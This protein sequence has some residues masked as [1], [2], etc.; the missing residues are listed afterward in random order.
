MQWRSPAEVGEA[1]R[2][3]ARRPAASTETLVICM[4]PPAMRRSSPV[5]TWT[6]QRWDSP[7]ASPTKT[8]RP[9]SVQRRSGD[10]EMGG[11]PPR[12]RTAS[13]VRRFGA[14]PWL[15]RRGRPGCRRSGHRLSEP[16]RARRS[17]SGDQA[18]PA[19]LESPVDQS[20][21]LT[22]VGG[23][24]VGLAVGGEVPVVQAGGGEGDARAVGGPGGHV[25]VP[26][27]VGELAGVAACDVDDEGVPGGRPRA[28]RR[29]RRGT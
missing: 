1:A 10:G 8:M 12:G 24:D 3:T 28:S 27:A 17:P 13:G 23:D 19:M 14:S 2:A 18:R 5:L 21:G 20:S 9:S 25:V 7:L 4:P 29:C 6:S 16:M 11:M 15:R 26:V 22:A